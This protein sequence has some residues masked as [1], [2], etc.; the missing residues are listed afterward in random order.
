MEADGTN[1]VRIAYKTDSTTRFLAELL[2]KDTVLPDNNYYLIPIDK[3]RF[4]QSDVDDSLWLPTF[5][6]KKKEDSLLVFYEPVA[7]TLSLSTNSPQKAKFIFYQQLSYEELIKNKPLVME[8]FKLDDPFVSFLSQLNTRSLETNEKMRKFYLIIIA[9]TNDAS[10]GKSSQKDVA[11]ITELFSALTKQTGITYVPVIV[12]GDAFNIGNTQKVLDTVKPSS[13]DILFFYYTGHGFRFEDD[14]SNYPRISFR[15]NNLQIRPENNLSV[16]SIYKQL[17]GKGAWVT[18][19]ISDCC[20]EKLKAPVPFGMNM[21]QPRATGPAGLKVNYDNFRK[22]FLPK[23]KS[24][25]I[26]GSASPNQ[27]A[28]GNP[29]LG[30]FFTNFFKRELMQSLYSNTGESSWWRISNNA[31]DKTRKQSLT[32]ECT[33]TPNERGRC[34]QRAEIKVV[35]LL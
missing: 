30:G 3:P 33:R 20:N 27:L 32:S 4:I 28:V 14:K 17:L 31:A 16:E 21:L 19:V 10:I 6:F 1:T 8:F 24:S 2:M 12:S 15:A 35:P 7:V 11:G 22:L 5:L 34:T 26:I 18:I 9:N 23:Q 13:N 29:D 25:I